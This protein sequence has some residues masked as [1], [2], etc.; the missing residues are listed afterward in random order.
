V[1][2]LLWILAVI[3]VVGGIVQLFR[4]QILWGIVLIIVSMSFLAPWLAEIVSGAAV[5]GSA[6]KSVNLFVSWPMVL[7]LLAVGTIAWWLSTK[8]RFPASSFL[9]AVV[10]GVFCNAVLF[11]MNRAPLPFTMIGQTLLGISIGSKFDR[12]TLIR[13]ARLGKTMILAMMLTLS[14]A[15]GIG[16]L[17]YL[18]TSIDPVTSLLATIPGGA[19]EMAAIALTLGYDVTLVTA[20]QMIRLFNMFLVAPGMTVWLGRRLA[21][22]GTEE[23]G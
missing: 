11:H 16:Y 23:N 15:L 17:F 3:L 7:M 14:T 6:Q 20:I 12:A 9:L 13:I 18:A 5:S 4:G 1:A 10:L 8:I 2:F 19:T 22:K 21:A